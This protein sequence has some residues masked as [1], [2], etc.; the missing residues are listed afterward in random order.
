MRF[1][2]IVLGSGRMHG[3]WGFDGAETSD[4]EGLLRRIRKGG[5]TVRRNV[6]LIQ[7]PFRL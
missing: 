7:T 3:G 4:G 1:R 6:V 2:G 5:R